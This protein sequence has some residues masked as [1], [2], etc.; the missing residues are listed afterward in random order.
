MT[1]FGGHRGIY[2]ECGGNLI[3][4]NTK[5]RAKYNFYHTPA[6]KIIKKGGVF[7]KKKIRS[8]NL[9]EKK[10]EK[11]IIF[12]LPGRKNNYYLICHATPLTPTWEQEGYPYFSI[13]NPIPRLDAREQLIKNSILPHRAL[14]HDP[15]GLG[16]SLG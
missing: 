13:K 5:I 7:K 2:S 8:P 14:S 3:E 4:K 6:G 1:N 10:F 15:R 11:N 12:T 16:S 9:I